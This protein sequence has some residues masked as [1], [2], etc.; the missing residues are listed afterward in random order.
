MHKEYQV[1]I[2]F[3]G[4]NSRHTGDKDSLRTKTTRSQIIDAL[5]ISSNR[6]LCFSY[7]WFSMQVKFDNPF[8]LCNAVQ[9]GSIRKT[10]FPDVAQDI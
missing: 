9:Y 10:L 7:L 3:L 5:N 4:S 8:D 1:A 2:I 6:E